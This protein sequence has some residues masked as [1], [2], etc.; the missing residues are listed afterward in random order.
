[1]QLFMINLKDCEFVNLWF[2]TSGSFLLDSKA[3]DAILLTP[4]PQVHYPNLTS[5]DTVYVECMMEFLVSHAV[6]INATSVQ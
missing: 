4:R 6:T 2:V 1:M 5:L 3:S